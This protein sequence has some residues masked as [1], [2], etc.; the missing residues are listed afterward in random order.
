MSSQPTR[1]DLAAVDD[2]APAPPGT[3]SLAPPVP[4]G[5]ALD[6]R[7]NS[8]HRDFGKDD[9]IA[10]AD[11]TALLCLSGKSDAAGTIFSGVVFD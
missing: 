2:L 11:L 3:R 10:K 4:K 1:W 7:Q 5:L 9:L 6:Y 8:V